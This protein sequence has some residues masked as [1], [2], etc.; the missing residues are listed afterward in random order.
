MKY[1]GALLFSFLLSGCGIPAV[2]TNPTI[3]QSL[4]ITSIIP[5][6]TP[7]AP[8]LS[9]LLPVGRTAI[10]GGNKFQVFIDSELYNPT[11]TY[12]D[13]GGYWIEVPYDPKINK[14]I[15]LR[16][17]ITNTNKGLY[18]EEGENI[19]KWLRPSKL[20]DSDNPVLVEKAK[21]LT[22]N[23]NTYEE[24]ARIIHEFIIGYLKFQPYGRHYLSSAS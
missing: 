24:K 3:T 5:S 19:E 7:E 15:V 11:P 13:Y 18:H 14:K 20:I 9:L 6:N 22:S 16:F 23:F 4:T 1:F 10:V 8:K 12:D 21:Q 17:T 2:S